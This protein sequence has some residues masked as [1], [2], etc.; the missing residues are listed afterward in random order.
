MKSAFKPVAAVLCIFVLCLCASCAKKETPQTPDTISF[1]E[2]DFS[3]TLPIYGVVEEKNP[4]GTLFYDGFIFDRYDKILERKVSGDTEGTWTYQ[5]NENGLLQYETFTGKEGYETTEYEYDENG[6]ITT[7]WIRSDFN[8]KDW[9]RYV[10]TYELDELDRPTKLTITNNRGDH[11]VQIFT[12]EY[13]GN[14]NPVRETQSDYGS[15]GYGSPKAV[16]QRENTY[17][18]NGDLVRTVTTEEGE[19]GAFVTTYK[20]GCV[21]QRTIQ[22]KSDEN[23]MSAADWQRF[24]EAQDLI[25]P[26]HCDSS[27]KQI[28]KTDRDGAAVYTYLLPENDAEATERLHIYQAILRDCCKLR[29]REEKDGSMQILKDDAVIARMET[30]RNKEQNRT[31]SIIIGNIE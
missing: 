24:D 25:Q 8:G 23:L 1:P 18:F 6:R 12:Y 11:S 22:S 17:N 20:Y 9:Y 30:G 14:S 31:F 2:D 10:Y 7:S 29:F 19:E 26:D 27:I 21:Q 28:D 16:Y 5:Y 13:D 3:V 15:Y 4:E